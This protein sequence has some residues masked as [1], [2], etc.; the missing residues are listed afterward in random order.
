ELYNPTEVD[1]SLAGYVLQYHSSNMT[2]TPYLP[3]CTLDAGAHIARHGYYLVGVNTYA[4]AEDAHSTWG[5][6]GSLGSGAGTVRLG[7]PGIG[8]GKPEALTVDMVGW[9]VGPTG[10]WEFEGMPVDVSAL[11]TW[12]SLERKAR[13]GSTDLT[14]GVGGSD[15]A[16]GNAYD[17]DRNSD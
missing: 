2:G 16:L 13:S 1:F 8:S 3:I 14:M 9:G 15:H 11:V 17:T 5:G 12:G 10:A 6:A 4:R 7:A